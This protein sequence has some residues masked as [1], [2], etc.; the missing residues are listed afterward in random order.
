M[1]KKIKVTVKLKNN[2]VE[3]QGEKD[4]RNLMHLDSQLKYKSTT[5]KPKKGK[6]SFKRNKKG[7]YDE[8][9]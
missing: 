6:G 4:E 7:V 1:K 5:I 9:V 8:N 2:V 3:V